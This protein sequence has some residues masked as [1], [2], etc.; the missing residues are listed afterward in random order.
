MHRECLA[1]PFSNNEPRLDC[2]Q[3][4]TEARWFDSALGAGPD[5]SAI[6]F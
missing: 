1:P 4:L 2:R 6:M 3:L 5:A